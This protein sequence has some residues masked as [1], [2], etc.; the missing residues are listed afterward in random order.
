M[1][2]RGMPDAAT[3]SGDEPVHDVAVVGFGPVGAA[4]TG[5]L[6]RRGLDVI[7]FDRGH[8]VYPQPRAFGLDHEAMRVFQRIGIA[9]EILPGTTLYRPSVYL[10]VDGQPIQR[11]DM[12]PP[13]YALGWAPAYT[14]DQPALE[15][16]LRSAALRMPNVTVR[17]G[18]EVTG[19]DDTPG[20][21]L[22]ATRNDDG[23]VDRIR[24]RYVVVCDGAASRVR[25]AR[26]FPSRR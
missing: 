2:A 21:A 14:F 5:L 1:T 22:L 12:R 10:G 17:L 7:A 16:S 20:S 4:L 15:V 25:R 24:A 3:H 13:P 8:E 6:G 9:D 26:C 23:T 11:F 19:I 18:E